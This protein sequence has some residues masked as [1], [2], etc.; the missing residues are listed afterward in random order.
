[1]T[2]NLQND[3]QKRARIKELCDLLNRASEAYYGGDEEI[4]SNYE[5]DSFFDELSSLEKETGFVLADSPT[6]RV[7]SERDVGEKPG[8]RE[9]H[10]FP[11]LSLAKTKSVSQL[12]EWAGDRPV[13]LSYKLDGLTLVLTYD[14]GM[15]QKVVTRGN[16]TAGNNITEL[17]DSIEGIPGKVAYTGHLVVRGEATISYTDFENINALIEDEDERYANPR[18][19]ASGTL[20][21]DDPQKV[22]E[23]HVSFHAFT[24]VYLEKEIG[25]WGDRMAFLKDLGFST[26]EYVRCDRVSLPDMINRFTKKVEDGTMDIPVDG[27]VIC[28]EDHAYAS[29]GSVTGHHATR[30]GLAFKWADVS[31]FS[32]LR[33]V[34]WSCAASTISP[35]AVF[36]PVSLEGTTVSRAS[37]CNIS[38]MERLGIGDECTLEIIKANKIIPKCISVKESSGSFRIPEVCPVCGSPTKIQ[39]SKRSGTKT[40]H[41]V[42]PDC[43]AKQGKKF[44]RFVSKTGMD[45][46]GLSIQTM[47]RFMNERFIRDFADIYRLRDHAGRIRELEGFGDRSVDNMLEAVERSR[48]VPATHFIY[49]LCIPMIGLDAA[50]KLVDALSFEG[51][52][53]RLDNAEG[54]EDID[55]IG[56][57]K[58][59]QIL[60]WYNE[61]NRRV[62][63]ELLEEVTVTRGEAKTKTGGKCAGL[64]FVIT[65]DVHHYKNRD[66]LKAYVE[67]E[68]GKVAGSVSGKTSFLINNDTE[69]TSSK[70]R[71]AREQNVPVISEDEFVERFG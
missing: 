4:I 70:N 19:L 23:R 69:S 16:G 7:G 9:V 60:L 24:L 14:Q 71:K 43:A 47:V 1:M 32:K 15:L 35:V 20:A 6:Q 36:E 39:V 21:L 28:Y 13:F 53:N 58:S 37:L 22:K 5:W 38:E 65:G 61:S 48:S 17:W 57:E 55:G 62:L 18:N 31:A 25:L 45:I 59:G 50:K 40:L 41:C 30:A 27:L 33:Y 66:E 52:L 67:A 49:A 44:A 29:S 12:Q 42:N 26:V 11:A 34:E 68:G 8:N 3:P 10:E 2:D 63:K 64:T 51:F 54:F 56:T 46:D